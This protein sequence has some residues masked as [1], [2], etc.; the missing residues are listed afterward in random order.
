MLASIK[1]MAKAEEHAGAST[2]SMAAIKGERGGEQ[3]GTAFGWVSEQL[4]D[5]ALCWLGERRGDTAFGW[6]DSAWD[7]SSG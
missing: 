4:G 6:S 3:N 2:S 7:G 1:G 5:T